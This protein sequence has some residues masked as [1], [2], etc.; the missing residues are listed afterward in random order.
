[1]YS[2]LVK[3]LIYKSPP[4]I[5]NSRVLNLIGLQF[6]RYICFS[7]ITYIIKKITTRPSFNDSKLK[8]MAISLEREGI[9]V[10]NSFLNDH[11]ISYLKEQFGDISKYKLVNENNPRTHLLHIVEYVENRIIIHDHQALK[12][13]TETLPLKDFSK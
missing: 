5:I 3:K 11:Q 8:Q 6:V 12:I 7:L 1:M 2:H 9:V 4:L 13:L 10:V